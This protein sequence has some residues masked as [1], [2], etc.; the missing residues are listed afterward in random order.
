M[1][2]GAKRRSA[3]RR[4]AEAG[5]AAPKAAARATGGHGPAKAD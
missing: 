5:V 3:L 2:R 1:R 4:N